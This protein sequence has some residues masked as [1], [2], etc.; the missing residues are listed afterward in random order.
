[1]KNK[2]IKKKKLAHNLELSYTYYLNNNYLFGGQNQE[3][4]L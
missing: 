3:T 2:A 4:D 1:M